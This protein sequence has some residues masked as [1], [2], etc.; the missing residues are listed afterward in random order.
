MSEGI[1]LVCPSTAIYHTATT[2]NGILAGGQEGSTS[3]MMG[4]H[5]KIGDIT[6]GADL[7]HSRTKL[8]KKISNVFDFWSLFLL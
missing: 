8:R 2:W 6:S 1:L 4:Q 3:H 7:V 5:N